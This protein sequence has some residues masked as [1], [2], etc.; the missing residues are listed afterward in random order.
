MDHPAPFTA[1]AVLAFGLL[2]ALPASE[3]A[4]APPHGSGAPAESLLVTGPTKTEVTGA[5]SVPMA[6]GA[7]HVLID[8]RIDGKGPFRMILDTGAATTVL[9]SDLVRELGL[10][11]LGTTRIGDP[12]NPL[13]NEVDRLEIPNVEVG[14][15]R[16][17]GVA[18]VGWR[19]P[20]LAAAVGA[21]GVL[22]LPTFRG[23]LLTIDYP[24]REV[25]IAPGELPPAD[26][27]NILPLD[28][29]LIAEIPVD[30]AGRKASAHLDIGN[31]SSLIVP[32]SWQGRLPTK[33]EVRKGKGM[34]A[35]GPAE[36][37]ITT[38]DG[39]LRIGE[40]V[41]HDPEVRFDSGLDHVNVGYGILRG[42]TLTLDQKNGR[43]RLVPGRI[44]G[45]N[46][47]ALG[48]A[49]V[50]AGERRR[51]GAALGMRSDGVAEIQQVLPGSPA[52]GA[53]L[54]AGDVLL[55]VDGR[56]MSNEALVTA[57]SGKDPVRLHVRRGEREID[58]V[59]FGRGAKDR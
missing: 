43:L 10:K 9:D 42:F 16:F 31:G 55:Q 1:I 48:G 44:T 11:S 19:G 29:H 58:V 36:F 7:S 39:D 50:P 38:L 54:E 34:R 2:V 25:E 30:V 3:A 27:R 17:E 24:K 49:P 57:L 21:R 46:P 18:A 12:S 35:S 23:C 45:P 15:A 13:A 6:A 40:H 52:A 41:F 53:G 59:V 56:P 26:G 14:G 4:A 47:T 5:T 37:T 33:G 51:L 32:G 20:S 8:V 22:G 28:T